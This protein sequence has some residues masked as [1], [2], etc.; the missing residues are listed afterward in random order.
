MTPYFWIIGSRQFQTTRRPLRGRNAQEELRAKKNYIIECQCW[1]S[2]SYL[3][4]LFINFQQ[5]HLLGIL[6]DIFCD[7]FWLYRTHHLGVTPQGVVQIRE[8]NTFN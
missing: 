3:A 7:L 8:H 1:A 5:V 6:Y 4:S 2:F